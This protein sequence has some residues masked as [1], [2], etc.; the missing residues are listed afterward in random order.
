MMT[1]ISQLSRVELQDLQNKIAAR[2]RE[3][4]QLALDDAKAKIGEMAQGLG[5]S[6]HQLLIDTGLIANTA[7]GR[8]AKM[9]ALNSKKVPPIYSNPENS[10]ENWSG[11]GRQ[12]HWVKAMLNSG[13]TLDDLRIAR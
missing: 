13:K 12:P 7:V 6:V 4:E 8:G 10:A 2:L 9:G 5:R 3:T 1:D 11:R